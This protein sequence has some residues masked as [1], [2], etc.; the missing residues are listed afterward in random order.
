MKF[1]L[2]ILLIIS[3][4]LVALFLFIDTGGNWEYILPLRGRKILAIILTGSAIGVSTIIFQTITNNRILTPSV[5]GLDSLYMLIQTM[6]VFLFGADTLTMMNRNLHFLIS[7]GFMMLFAL[8]LYRYLF[9]REGQNIYF[10]LLVGIILGTLFSSLSSF[11]EML[12]DPNEFLVVQDS[13]FASF[14]NINTHLLMISCLFIICI[15]IYFVRYIKYL[16][17][18]SLGKHQAINLGIEYNAV[19][20]RLLMIVA[21]FVSVSTA[22]VGPITFLGLLA[23]NITY[24]FLGTYKHKFLLPGSIFI[25]IIALFGGQLFVERI[26]HFSTTVSVIINLVGG[27]YFLYL[28]I[29]ENK[30]W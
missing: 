19:I 24:Q 27:C 13:M 4:A 2:S 15:G 5:I 26:I 16:D 22:L 7:V 17:V 18:L 14:N 28:L 29:R 9:K 20:K 21:V 25:S 1:K 30:S 23:A 10:L 11:M 8:L 6:V 12:I 3:A